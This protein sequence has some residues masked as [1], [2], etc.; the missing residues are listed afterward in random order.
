M[1]L[2]IGY[3]KWFIL[4]EHKKS[5]LS[6]NRNKIYFLYRIPHFIYQSLK[7]NLYI[8]EVVYCEVGH[9]EI[10]TEQKNVLSRHEKPLCIRQKSIGETWTVLLSS[11]SIRTDTYC[12][13]SESR[14][15]L[16]NHWKLSRRTY[17]PL[18]QIL[19]KILQG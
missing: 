5:F 7:N 2:K 19:D 18:R 4:T 17:K 12:T 9:G 16:Y 6:K 14:N 3:V 1:K 15:K 10:W 13:L 8:I 11:N